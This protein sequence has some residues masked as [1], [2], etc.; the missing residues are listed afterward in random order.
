M[1]V[2]DGKMRCVAMC[3]LLFLAVGCGGSTG[4][5]DVVVS[6][7]KAWL[8]QGALPS[9]EVHLVGVNISEYP[10]WSKMSMTTYWKEAS[11]A[12]GS[13]PKVYIM[14]FGQG[15][16]E[17][18]TLPK[19]DPI[20]KIWKEGYSQYLFVLADIPGVYVDESG[21]ADARRLILPLDVGSWRKAKYVPVGTSVIQIDVAKPPSGVYCLNPPAGKVK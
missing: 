21:D 18:Q 13:N 15:K 3:L 14:K 12:D 2:P 10:N 16:P 17:T 8:D 20:W 19:S 1:S 9:V 7:D 4:R 6:M 5:F 11:R